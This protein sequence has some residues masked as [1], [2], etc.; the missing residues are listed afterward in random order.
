M[1]SRYRNMNTAQ[2][3]IEILAARV[4]RLGNLCGLMMVSGVMLSACG[5]RQDATATSGAAPHADSTADQ[6][7][8]AERTAGSVAWYQYAGDALPGNAK[9]ILTPDGKTLAFNNIANDGGHL[10]LDGKG[11]LMIDTHPDAA[12][13]FA[14]VSLPHPAAYPAYM[15][16]VAQVE[17]NSSGYRAADFEIAVS[18][19]DSM[20]GARVKAIVGPNSAKGLEIEKFDGERSVSEVVDTQGTHV[21]QLD[22]TLT[23]P[24]TGSFSVYVD[25]ARTPLVSQS[26]VK[27]RATGKPG[28]NYVGMGANS[29]SSIYQSSVDWLVWTSAGAFTPEQLRG[30]LPASLGQVAG[31]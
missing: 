8:G 27:L 31:Y 16:L 1:N 20:N 22:V 30:K 7:P 3:G 28:D 17:G 4:L 12:P 15:T 23:G 5:D 10:S 26:N 29:S 2:A 13:A 14:K 18:P 19:D 6:Q 25:G 9:A 21:Y 24:E 11:H